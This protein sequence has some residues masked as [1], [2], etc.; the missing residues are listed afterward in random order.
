MKVLITL[1]CPTLFDPMDCSLPGS[2]VHEILETRILK[3][4]V[5]LLSR[6]SSRPRN[7]THVFCV[8]CIVGRFFRVWATRETHVCSKGPTIYLFFSCTSHSSWQ[9]STETSTELAQDIVIVVV[10]SLSHVWLFATTWT[11]AQQASLSFIISRS[12]LKLLSIESVIPS[13]HLILC[14]LLLL[15]SIF[16]NIRVFSKESVLCI[17]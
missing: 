1:S 9:V 8:S 7:Q 12:L 4:V 3:W 6:R 11:A 5:V 15:P 13:N 16:P 10:Q 14:R 17:R 2:S